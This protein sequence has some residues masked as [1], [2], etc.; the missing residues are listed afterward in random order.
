MAS[1]LRD[2]SGAVAMTFAA[3]IAVVLAV[4]GA[5]VDYGLIL[6]H[7]QRL[8]STADAAVLAGAK[9]LSFANHKT[10]DARKTVEN[11]VR[12]YASKN[13]SGTNGPGGLITSAI[14]FNSLQVG[15]KLKQTLHTQFAGV[16]GYP[17]IDIEVE[18]VAKVVGQPNLCLLALDGSEKETFKVDK[19]S[20]TSGSGCALFS[21]STSASG[22]SIRN[23]A[24][25]VASNICSSGGVELDG[26]ANPAPLVD[27]PQFED[28]LAPQ[29]SPIVGPCDFKS[30][31]IRNENKILFPGVYCRG[32][33]I[34][35]GSRVTF[36][37]G[38]YVIASGKFEVKG[39]SSITGKDVSF[40]LGDHATLKFRKDS[41]INLEASK[42]G[43]MPGILF[44]ASR[45]QPTYTKHKIES[46]NAQK[47]VGTLYF[48]TST[49][50]VG[51]D[52]SDE[53]DVGSAAAYT[54]IVANKIRVKNKSRLTLN[55]DYGLTDV[56]VPMGIRGVA[57]PVQL[58]F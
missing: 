46:R 49:F 36:T 9:R 31:R 11:V 8:Q 21:N 1:F 24:H 10:G 43:V 27:C 51:S 7:K 35:K 18:A 26:T 42:S 6:R 52:F 55:T 58:V 40:Y 41:S 56:P 3:A 54:A 29:A 33:K 22:I 34:D 4:A 17:T 50:E 19:K 25:V 48:P 16:I 5:S 12:R 14:N 20:V 37:Q 47:L 13:G 44:F 32:I 39:G 53:A 30:V 23:K 2:R 57:Q 15:V 45:K 38:L 28:P